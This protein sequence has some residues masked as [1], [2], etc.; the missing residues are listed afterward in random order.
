MIRSVLPTAL[1]WL[2]L[3]P[4]QLRAHDTP[5]A[6]IAPGGFVSNFRLTDHRGITRELY[7]ESTAKAVVLVFTSSGSPRALQTASALRALRAR[8]PANDVV[9]WQIESNPTISRATLAAEQT[10]FNNDTPVLLDEAQI[11]AAE[12]GATRQLETFVLGA[13]PFAQLAYRGPLDN[14]E[15]GT[16][17]A[18]TQNYAADAVAAVLAGRA[19]AAST[20]EMP[21][22]AP[23]L[24][25]L[26]TP[27]IRYATDVAP[28]VIRRCISCHSPGNIAPHVYGKFDDLALRADEIRSDL[29]TQ[30]MAPWHADPQVGL[31]ANDVALTPA[32]V[33]TLY[34]WARAKQPL[35]TDADPLT[36][37]TPPAPD[38]PLGQPDLV[39]S[40]PKQDL[41][42]RGPIDYRYVTINVPGA[43]DR[44]LRA[45]VV[46]PG[47]RSVVHHAL[48]FEGTVLDVLLNAGG[49]GGFF[50]GYVPGLQQTFYPEGTGKRLRAN[51]ALTFQMHY[52]ATGSAETDQTEI[53]FYFAPTAPARE[54][55][56]R[57]A[58]NVAITIPPGAKD[59][60]LE[61][62]FVPSAS[63][64]VMLY[65]LTPHM[66]YRGKR[67][68]YEAVYRD[69]TSEVLLNVPKYDFGWQSQYRLAQPKRL[70]AGTTIRVVGAFDNS[71]QNLDNPDPRATVRFGEQ[72]ND[73]MFIGYLNYTEL[74]DR[75]SG[76]APQLPLRIPVRERASRSV[77][78]DLAKLV[79]NGTA[80]FTIA[81]PL[82][83]G[84]TATDATGRISGTPSQAGRYTVPVTATNGFGS[85]AAVVDLMV[86]ASAGAPVITTQPK[87]TRAGAGATVRLTVGA[88]GAT[89]L[90][91][92]WRFRGT[93][94]RSTTAPEL[95]LGNVTAADAGDYTCTVVG[96]QGSVTSAVA[97]LSVDLTSLS[98][99]SAR[100]NVGTG[101]DAVIPGITVRGAQPKTLLIRAAG[102]AL[103]A[104]GVGGT[105]ANPVLTVFNAAG[106]KILVNDNW[107]EGPDLPTLRDAT[108]RQGAFALPE[109]SRDAAMLVTVPP[110]SY[111][112]QVTPAAGSGQAGVAIVE[113][114]EADATPSTLVNLSCRARVGM[115]S[116]ILIAGFTIAGTAPKRVLIRGIGPTLGNLG[117]A[118]T[119][120]DPKLEIIRGGSTTVLASNDNWDAPLAPTFTGV[121]AFALTPGSR[122]SALVVTLDP[123]SYTAQVSGVGNG[124]GIAI[125][126]VYELP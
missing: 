40:I 66:H 93:A 60:E 46:R 98:N 38:W 125:V 99:L 17:D 100:A 32:E 75:V 3:L 114:Y 25:L 48:V 1:A 21:A 53:G 65:E 52:T 104:L 111:T 80:T 82:P 2:I 7:Y 18:P 42:A 107:S 84:L 37:T 112:V 77:D 85:S 8:F 79:T 24:A 29:L 33:G 5:I 117:V 58:A 110:G 11:V 50:A 103:A 76:A 41:P 44:W 119:L 109:G 108:T 124:T 51:G 102:P 26:P 115:G 78:V 19:P 91:F 30:R 28:I 83:P 35:G 31:F 45:A 10:L 36:R 61:A 55:V 14:A 74:A 87:S 47:N 120:A 62:T 15:P 101:A 20:V 68:R 34:A 118:D 12:L 49:L 43:A 71:A 88:D 106:E 72:T 73:E 13:P 94:L 90:R 54:L 89:P 86:D 39:V 63:R 27:S 4:L 22:S 57:A 56:T 70:P 92:D 59:H 67:F 116:D 96:A 9:I 81:R 6:G 97:T 105:L 95:T 16:L 113:V 64:D 69:G 122:D 126:E 121:G 23:A 123:G